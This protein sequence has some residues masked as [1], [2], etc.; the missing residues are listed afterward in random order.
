[1][2]RHLHLQLFGV[3]FTMSRGV[4]FV[5]VLDCENGA[6]GIQRARF[7]YTERVSPSVS[8]YKATA[9]TYQA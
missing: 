8:D 7:L 9:S 6:I 5:D 3:D 2:Q 4:L 1:M